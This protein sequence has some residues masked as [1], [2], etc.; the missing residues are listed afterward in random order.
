MVLDVQNLSCGYSGKVVVHALSLSVSAGEIL[1]ILGPNGVGKTT[2][3]RSIMGQLRP[4]TGQI[5]IA[6]K[7]I[8]Q[9]SV[10]A[11]AHHVAYV[12]QAHTP[13]FPFSVLDV[14]LTGRTVHTGLFSAPSCKDKMVAE[15]QLDKLG[16]SEL[17]NR[18]YTEISGG[19]RQLVLLAR[20]LAQGSPLMVLDE[21]T[22]NLDFGNQ[23]KVLEQISSLA[24]QGL[25]VVM[26]THS[27]NHALLCADRVLLM[28]PSGQYKTGVPSTIISEKNL[29]D[30]YGVDVKLVTTD[31]GCHGVIHSCVPL[32]RQTTPT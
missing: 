22:S 19:E 18:S 28:Q 6:G 31:A 32:M 27:P 26:T 17:K 7:A 29:Y 30:A 24:A 21:P 8:H 16:I 9:L 13:P 23:I 20:A 3:F 4:I 10:K 12:P 2:L 25:S 11:L 1:C 5:T 14:V 15:A